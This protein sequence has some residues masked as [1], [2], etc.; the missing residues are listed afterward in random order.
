M[1]LNSVHIHVLN[2]TL[3]HL[4]SSESPSLNKFTVLCP[5]VLFKFLGLSSK[6]INQSP[7]NLL[8]CKWP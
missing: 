4:S 8:N 7:S 6:D 5:K 1:L 2:P 3:T